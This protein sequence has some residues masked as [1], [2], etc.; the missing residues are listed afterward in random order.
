MK[1]ILLGTTGLFGAV[2]LFASAATA[3]TPTVTIGGFIDFQAGYVSDDNDALQRST[4]FRNDT[5]VSIRVD[6]KSDAG[7]GYG[8][9]IDLEADVSSFGT[10]AAGGVSSDADNQGLNASRTY[11]FLDG[12]WGRFELGSNSGAAET[13]GLN[14]SNIAHATGGIAGA[15]TYFAAR[16]VVAGAFIAVPGSFT[17]I[18]SFALNGDESFGNNNKITY[19]TPRIEGFQA[20]VSYA[21]DLSDRGQT[22]GRLDG[23][24]AGDIID[25]GLTYEGQWDEA[26][27]GFAATYQIGNDETAAPAE[28]IDA[29][30]VGGTAGWAGF[31]LAASYADFGESLGT[32]GLDSSYWTAGAAY[33]FGPFGASVTYLD[34]TVET[35]TGDNEFTNLVVG[36]DYSLAPGLTPYAEV[37]FYEFD[38][39]AVG[40]TNDNEGTAVILGTQL[41]F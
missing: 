7:L 23:N 2:A 39:S 35:G 34:S 16:P 3:E 15:W 38:G 12:G 9:V 10:V 26:A 17:S 13:M 24:D 5:E 31:S 40:A 33:D 4:G 6:G 41:A 32:A 22:V 36:A 11:I 1:K 21:P 27:L 30:T 19:Y 25:V 18:G 28:D 29:W 14:A 8:A 20:G 37:S